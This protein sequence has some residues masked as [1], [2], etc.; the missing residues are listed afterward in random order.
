MYL[1]P[2]KGILSWRSLPV[3]AIIGSK[4]PPRDLTMVHVTA[5]KNEIQRSSIKRFKPSRN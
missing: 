3:K 2:K 1:N 5:F 4:L